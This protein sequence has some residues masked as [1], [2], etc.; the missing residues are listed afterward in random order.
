MRLDRIG[1]HAN[2]G[3]LPPEPPT[4]GSAS[5]VEIVLRNGRRMIMRSDIAPEVLGRLLDVVDR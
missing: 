4:D 5:P 1:G 3:S 2:D